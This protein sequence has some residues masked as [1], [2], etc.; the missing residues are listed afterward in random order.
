MPSI[1]PIL[2]EMEREAKTPRRVLERVPTERLS[3]KPHPKSK[4][5]GQ[6]AWHIAS[7][8]YR[9]ARLAQTDDGDAMVVK[10]PPLPESTAELV[11][12]FDA[13]VAEAKDLL[14]KLDGDSL[15]RIF[16]F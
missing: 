15:S 3:W 14:A 10:E 1:G 5:L 7:I 12:A 13:H 6:L 8:P 4:S 9:V 11:A 16:T 2:D